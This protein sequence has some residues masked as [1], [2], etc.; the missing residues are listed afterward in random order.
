MP[1]P[2][3]GSQQ[4]TGRLSPS[5]ARRA[6]S[7]GRL[8]STARSARYMAAIA[9]LDASATLLPVQIEEIVDDLHRE[10]ADT[11]SAVP[12]G[13]VAHCYLGAPFE[14]HTLTVD[15]AII[16]HYRTGEVLPGPLER[17]RALARSEHYGVIEVYR[18][19]LVCVHSDGS[20]VTLEEKNG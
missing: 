5:V 9:R 3:L 16:E 1:R 6:P 18:D 10:F 17:A 8:K 12:L 2:L 7:A 13:F 19:R 4:Q 14:A 15:G 20:V 11:W